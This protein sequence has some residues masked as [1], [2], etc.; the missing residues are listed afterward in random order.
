[1]SNL[2]VE[3]V[4]RQLVAA[5]ARGDS[6]ADVLA[7]LEAELGEAG[8]PLIEKVKG[9][10]DDELSMSEVAK[11]LSASGID[12]GFATLQELLGENGRNISYQEYRQ[13]LK[14]LWDRLNLMRTRITTTVAYGVWVMTMALSTAGMLA[15]KV[16]PTYSSFADEVGGSLPEMTALLYD[17]EGSA[18]LSVG[19]VFQL[20]LVALLLAMVVTYRRKSSFAKFQL[21]LL[22][23]SLKR[24]VVEYMALA[25]RRLL[26]GAGDVA[27]VEKVSA[28]A[29]DVSGLGRKA[30]RFDDLLN[31]E[32]LAT[33][34]VGLQTG[35]QTVEL[36]QSSSFALQQLESKA[37]L[38]SRVLS[39]SI[40]LFL[41][42]FV[43]VV[44]IASYLP[45]FQFGSVGY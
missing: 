26:D 9:H 13:L 24:L 4:C 38:I 7:I 34:R 21:M 35:M 14:P 6:K 5:E 29:V 2:L 18:L 40:Y 12:V 36:E 20:I 19:G 22:I 28:Q 33:Y 23:P 44:V 27:V 39:I 1:M 8:K 25:Y 41:A 30:E 43:A 16:V 10:F 17:P 42:V 37:Q 32:S 15:V 45:I 3:C 31:S 11:T